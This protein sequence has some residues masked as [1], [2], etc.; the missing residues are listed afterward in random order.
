MKVT[1]SRAYKISKNKTILNIKIKKFNHYLKGLCHVWLV[2]FVCTA[3][4]TS[5]VAMELKVIEEI[6]CI[7]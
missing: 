6:I 7:L 1:E 5:S 4:K 2:D 3:N